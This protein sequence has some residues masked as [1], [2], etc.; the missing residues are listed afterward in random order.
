MRTVEGMSLLLSLFLHLSFVMI[1]I[2]WQMPPKR[3]N[4]GFITVNLIEEG[5]ERAPIIVNEPLS[6][7]S[8][9]V[10]PSLRPAEKER[11]V[12]PKDREME[13]EKVIEEALHAIEAKKRLEKLARLK[14]VISSTVTSKPLH[15]GRDISPPLQ[16]LSSQRGTTVTSS[17]EEYAGIVKGIIQSNWTYPE[18]VKKGLKSRIVILV[19]RDGSLK[20]TEFHSS[21]DRLFDYSVKNAILKSSPLPPPPEEVEIELRFSK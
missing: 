21:G 19:Q 5:S 8:P 17:P 12:K 2:T 16:G 10:A 11:V 20:I 1:L 4:P 18:V 14:A 9:E 3:I 6:L 15:E 13:R 7:K